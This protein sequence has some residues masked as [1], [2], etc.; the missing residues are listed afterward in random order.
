MTIT[1]TE[2]ATDTA[3]TDAPQ[4]ELSDLAS[5]VGSG[6]HVRIGRL[7]IGGSFIG[8]IASLVVG[9]FLD[10]ERISPTDVDV[11]D[12]DVLVQMTSAHRL[13]LVLLFALPA[14]LGLAMVI[15]PLQIGAS[16]L[17][18]GR[19][20]NLAFWTW[21]LGSILWLA[22]YLVGGG[23][24]GSDLE[25]TD[26]WLLATIVVIAA[27]CLAS[28]CVVTTVLGL[29]TVGMTLAR[30]PLFSFSMLVAGSIWLLTL[31]VAIAN[32]LIAYLDHRY[33]QVL[34]G[35][36][37]TI[38][39]QLSWLVGQPQIYVIAIPVL[40]IIGDV[41]PVFAGARQRMYA[42]S[43]V[44][45]GTF[46]ALSIG[47]W[48]QF[49]MP[50]LSIDESDVLGIADDPLYV[51]MG[52]L[53]IVPVLV[54]LGLSLETLRAPTRRFA[55]PLVGALLAGLALLLATVA[56]AL[57]VIEPL[58][59]FGTT[60]FLGQFLLTVGAVL[61]GVVAALWYWASKITGRILPEAPGL[62]V[63][64][65]VFGGAL[66]AG[67]AYVA[68]GFLDQVDSAAVIVDSA[69]DGVEALNVVAT[70]GSGLLLI[71][72]LGTVGALLGRRGDEDTPD[73]PWGGHT[74]EWAT[75]SPPARGNFAEAPEVSDE[76]PLF[77]ESTNAEEDAPA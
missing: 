63:P 23:P 45:I 71:G 3:G 74:L 43:M 69:P 62:L 2:P 64:L 18:F 35:L 7:F 39:A 50:G 73:D 54:I 11:L 8:L 20:A 47:S 5:I 19:A 42:A 46:G 30:V 15:V 24:G 61:I 49:G 31:P 29:R 16:T 32:L 44:A 65:V 66:L 26:L 33:G 36:N 41:V 67:G 4:G 34:F 53:A 22:G 12:A 9:F 1:E 68:A 52:L 75:A 10:V 55:S 17:A 21:S 56:G 76:C 72:V 60:A 58:D 40:G 14:L 28:V 70:I 37:E 25:G 51:G 6:D 27:L 77:T 59:L 13:G 48:A 38:L 57:Y